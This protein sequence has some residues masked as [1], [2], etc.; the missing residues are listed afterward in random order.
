MRELCTQPGVGGI[1]RYENDHY[2]GGNPWVLCTLWLAL[3]ANR[4]GD[5]ATVKDALQWVLQNQTGTGLL[6]EQVDKEKGG[7]GWVVPLTWSHA[8]YV[9][10]IIEHFA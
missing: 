4:R 9:L 2:A 6:P 7:P 10:T 8:M 5:A 1:R 3:D